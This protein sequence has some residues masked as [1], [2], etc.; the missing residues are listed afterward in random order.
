MESISLFVDYAGGPRLLSR[1][2]TPGI[3]VVNDRQIF[4]IVSGLLHLFV[5][6]V[7]A[8]GLGCIHESSLIVFI[9]SPVRVLVEI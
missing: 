9:F 4:Q 6:L 2:H 5:E 1:S 7:T 8:S 3:S